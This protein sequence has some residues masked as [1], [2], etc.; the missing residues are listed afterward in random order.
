MQVS[1]ILKTPLLVEILTHGRSRHI[2]SPT[3]KSVFLCVY[4]WLEIY[5]KIIRHCNTTP[6]ILDQIDR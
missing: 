2:L 1:V 4:V 5:I 6:S 3:D